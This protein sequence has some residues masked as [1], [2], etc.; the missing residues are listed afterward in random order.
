[1]QGLGFSYGDY[2]EES[3]QS[4]KLCLFFGFREGMLRL[5]KVGAA[6]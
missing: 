2:V 3:E 6:L 5:T 1:M 4:E